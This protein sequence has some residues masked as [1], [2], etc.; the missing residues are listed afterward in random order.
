MLLTLAIHCGN[1][2]CQAADHLLDK[3]PWLVRAICFAM[4]L[5]FT[6]LLDTILVIV[7]LAGLRNP[8]SCIVTFCIG[9]LALT[10][11]GAYIC[12]AASLGTS[13]GC[14]S[15]SSSTQLTS[16]HNVTAAG[17]FHVSIF[18]DVKFTVI[19]ALT[20]LVQSCLAGTYCIVVLFA[21][22]LTAVIQHPLVTL[23]SIPWLCILCATRL[24]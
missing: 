10:A 12:L 23:V 19:S 9:G 3:V 11:G 15:S 18:I 14:S 2:I 8:T 7:E 22:M 24:F 1:R 6:V 21:L 17:L 5:P 16:L 20:G 13:G 4:L